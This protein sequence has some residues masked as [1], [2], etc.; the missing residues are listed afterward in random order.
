[1]NNHKKVTI[2][3]AFSG[4]I[5]AVLFFLYS[6]ALLAFGNMILYYEP[7]RIIAAAEFLFLFL[8]FV[9][10]VYYAYSKLP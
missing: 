5:T 10:A 2:I 3:L 8:S 4:I 1:M 9:I 7:D 6:F